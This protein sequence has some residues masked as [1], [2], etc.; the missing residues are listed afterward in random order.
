MS[1]Q[2]VNT[3]D[4]IRSIHEM[5]ERVIGEDIELQTHID[6]DTGNF[7]ADPGQVDQV[8]MN[9]AVN[10]R[11]AMPSGGRLTMETS[12]CVLRVTPTFVITRQQMQGSMFVIAVSDTGVGMDQETLSH[13][14]EPFFTTKEIGKGTGL[15]LSI[16]YGIVKQSD[17]YINCYERDT[18]GNDLHHLSPA[19][20][21]RNQ[22]P[23]CRRV[24]QDSPEG[25]R[26][27]TAGG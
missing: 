12:N 11:D 8:L 20:S 26:D 7:L 13:I 1:P 25:D 22:C 2:V 9:L 15:G 19:D 4:L 17:G 5:L 3:K 6:P 24:R 27:N 21:R 10:A 23:P 18:Q 16:V 14:Y